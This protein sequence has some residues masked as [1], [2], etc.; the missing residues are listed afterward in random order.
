MFQVN[1]FIEE[2]KHCYAIAHFEGYANTWWD[3]VKRFGNVLNKG[4]PPLWDAFKVFM[5]LRY[6]LKRYRHELLSKVYN[7]R[8]GNYASGDLVQGWNYHDEVHCDVIPMQACHLLLGIP[9]KY[10]RSSK[11]DGRTNRY[12]FK[13]NGQ[14]F[15]LHPLLLSQV[16][17]GHQKLRKLKEKGKKQCE[18]KDQ[19]EKQDEEEEKRRLKGKSPS[20]ML[21]KNK[22]LFK[23][24]DEKTPMLLL[25]YAFH[26][27]YSTSNI[28]HYIYLVL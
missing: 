18:K 17:D 2:K 19:T 12:S 13:L 24:K 27:N 25:A 28:P 23:D 7:L 20:V 9:W 16:N 3:Y 6:V 26:A 15:T 11:L 1:D 4:Q 21:A 14:K 22:D 10:D 8:Q 5:R